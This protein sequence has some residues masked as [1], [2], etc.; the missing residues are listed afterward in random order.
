[1]SHSAI[2]LKA[3]FTSKQLNAPITRSEAYD[4]LGA[5]KDSLLKMQDRLDQLEGQGLSFEGTHQRHKQYRRGHCVVSAGSLWVA[6]CDTSE[7]PG[8]TGDWALAAK[9]GRDAR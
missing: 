4:L 9:A 5:L 7:T 3:N 2:E 1:M 8:K 6:A